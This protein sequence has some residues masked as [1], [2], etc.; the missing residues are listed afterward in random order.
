MGRESL[1][2]SVSS[3]GLA[4]PVR[5]H[6][7]NDGLRATGN[8]TR[9]GLGGGTGEVPFSPGAASPEEIPGSPPVHVNSLLSEGTAWRRN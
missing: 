4:G 3:H 9:D 6:S 5:V 2:F 8:R 7:T 1:I